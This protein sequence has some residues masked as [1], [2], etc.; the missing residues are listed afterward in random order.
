M[1]SASTIGLWALMLGLGAFCFAVGYMMA[2]K[3]YKRRFTADLKKFKSSIN[4]RQQ[5]ADPVVERYR[6]KEVVVTAPSTQAKPREEVAAKARTSYLNYTRQKPQ[7]DFSRIGESS[8]ARKQDLT[9][10][11]GIGP[12]IEQRLNEIGIYDY[13]QI[14]RLSVKDIRVLTDLIDFFPGRIEEDNWMAQAT[15]LK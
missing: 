8:A 11:R 15:T 2:R 13:E 4:T 3:R 9:L 12:Y 14:S 5:S 1:N 7:L 10:I 6:S